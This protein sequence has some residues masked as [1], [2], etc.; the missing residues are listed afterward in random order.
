MASSICRGCSSR[1]DTRAD[2]APVQAAT[3]PVIKA[4]RCHI[5]C[6]LPVLMQ[7][8]G[9]NREQVAEAGRKLGLDGTYIAR[10]YIEQIQL[11]KLTASF[12]NVTADLRRRFVVD[13]E[14][15]LDEHSLGASP[16]IESHRLISGFSPKRLTE[17]ASGP[18]STSGK[19]CMHWHAHGPL[20]HLTDVTSLP[21]F[22]SGLDA[23]SPIPASLRAW[24]IP[25]QGPSTHHVPR[26]GCWPRLVLMEMDREDRLLRHIYMDH[27]GI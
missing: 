6:S 2:P 16:R 24:G 4:L 11:A 27:G 17:A 5:K 26:Q 18:L 23:T 9:K 10:S 25:M 22:T 13:G 20:R 7:I 12:Q 14:P 19:A 21:L 1:K 15:L 3:V 8:Q